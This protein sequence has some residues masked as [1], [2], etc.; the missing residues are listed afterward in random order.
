MSQLQ[1]KKR[2]KAKQQLSIDKQFE[3][4]VYDR[5]IELEIPRASYSFNEIE[6][7]LSQRFESEARMNMR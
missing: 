7:Q 4:D 2:S 6:R 3:L 1:I 5:L